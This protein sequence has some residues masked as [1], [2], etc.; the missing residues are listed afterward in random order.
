MY[1]GLFGGKALNRG[2]FWSDPSTLRDKLYSVIGFAGFSSIISELVGMHTKMR[3][4]FR[5]AYELAGPKIDQA[6]ILQQT[7][8]ILSEARAHLDECVRTVTQSPQLG[9]VVVDFSNKV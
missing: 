3:A 8:S 7:S 1:D 2:L 9:I 6:I 5:K 4:G